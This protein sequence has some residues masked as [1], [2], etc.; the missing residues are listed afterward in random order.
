MSMQAEESIRAEVEKE[1]RVKKKSNEIPEIKDDEFLILTKKEKNAVILERVSNLEKRELVYLFERCTGCYLCEVACPTLAIEAVAI[2]SIARG[3]AKEPKLYI[4]IK[5][6][7]FCAI[8]VEACPFNAYDFRVN[9]KSEKG[10]EEHVRFERKHEIK[11]NA[12]LEKEEKIKLLR[13]IAEKCPRN[14]LI[15][16][17]KEVKLLLKEEDCIYCKGCSGSFNGIEVSFERFIEGSVSI[18]NELCQGCGACAVVCPTKAIYYPKPEKEGIRV[19]KTKVNELICNYCGACE[20]VCPTNAI[21]VRRSN[22]KYTFEKKKPWTKMWI[23]AF[24]RLKK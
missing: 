5:K 9:G 16:D 20:R 12:N 8:C 1:G 17:E 6:C 14:A 13:S 7:T 22:I 3:I 4:D 2:G 18:D 23:E 11:D 19:E 10:S 15:I 21:D 24:E